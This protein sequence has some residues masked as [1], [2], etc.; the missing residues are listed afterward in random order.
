MSARSLLGSFREFLPQKGPAA[1]ARGAGD[2]ARVT[3]T[4]A[5]RAVG[6]VWSDTVFVEANAGVWPERRE[7]SP[8]LG[9]EAR[10]Q[11]AAPAGKSRGLATA[12]DRSAI[13]RRIACAIARDTRSGIVLSAALFD[14]E[15][16]EVRLGPNTLLER[17]LW[18][19]AQGGGNAAS[20]ASFGG[21]ARRAESI[22]ATSAVAD[23]WHE[24]WS[25]RRNPLRPFDAYFLADPVGRWTPQS[26]PASQIERGIRD[27]ARLWFDSVLKVRRVEWRPFV[28]DRQKAIGTAVHRLLAAA[29][30]GTPA[31]G[32]FSILPTRGAAESSL[33]A[34]LDRFRVLWPQDRYWESF[35][36][37][38]GR[39]ARE[40]LTRVFDVAHARYAAVE[41][42][43]PDGA[44]V[45]VGPAGRFRVH[46]RIDL[47]IADR[48]A[49]AGATVDIVDFK[50]GGGAALT[51]KRMKSTGEALQL[52]IYLLAA[53]WAG[54][55]GRVWMLKP[56][57]PPATLNADEVEASVGKLDE[58]GR[59]L[60]TGIYGA[61]TPDRDEHT[62]I[63]EWPLACAPIGLAT[64]E[65]KFAAT[66]GERNEEDGGDDDA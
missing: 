30:Q 25:G 28:R 66:F 47:V 56:E 13:E 40:M 44:T 27:P 58:L 17:V 29:L 6:L 31:G 50:T 36:L 55:S 1:D 61:L 8:W 18:G 65:S 26:L 22:E 24:I 12:D 7:P 64:L 37:D 35:H 4:T 42:R 10:R 5:R 23:R 34:E 43:L 48:P 33:A 54:A 20:R 3:L 52:G 53:R 2:F 60:A 59:H 45:P 62:R 15:E 11:L 46:G 39:A 32:G 49:W 51:A 16:P 57:D 21:R 41:I 63:F 9:D 14:E 19:Q 38:V